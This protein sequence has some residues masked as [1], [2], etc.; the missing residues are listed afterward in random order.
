[1]YTRYWALVIGIVFILVAVLGFIP[2]IVQA[3]AVGE[4]VPLVNAGYG[5]LLGLFPVN[6]L[7]NV[8]HLLVGLAGILSWRTYGAARNFS[9]ALFIVYGLFTI[10]G[11]IPGLNTTFGLVPLFGNDIWLHAVTA[12]VSGY[13]GYLAPRED[14]NRISPEGSADVTRRVS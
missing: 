5:Y 14:V 7:H 4:P 1:M 6:I 10:M 11:L 8:V 13:F 12:I 3:P 9:R 2:G